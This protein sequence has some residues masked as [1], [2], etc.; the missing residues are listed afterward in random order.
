[1]IL[2]S[3]SILGCIIEIE[4]EPINENVSPETQIIDRDSV[5]RDTV[6][7][8][9]VAVDFIASF[10]SAYCSGEVSQLKSYYVDSIK[11]RAGSELLKPT[12]RIAEKGGGAQK[13]NQF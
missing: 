9:S 3:F 4:D 13:E 10:C 2:L 1:M 5:N 12:W 7:W 8:D 11:V 6:D